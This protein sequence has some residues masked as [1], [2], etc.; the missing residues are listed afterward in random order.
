MLQIAE[1]FND[2]FPSH[3]TSTKGPRM[4]EGTLERIRTS[5]HNAADIKKPLEWRF[6]GE[7]TEHSLFAAKNK[8][9]Y[10]SIIF[11]M[12]SAT[13]LARWP[14]ELVSNIAILLP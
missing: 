10:I 2:T 4:D 11:S 14:T 9:K 8:I 12:L 3:L 5:I 13:S 7:P 6:D 1:E